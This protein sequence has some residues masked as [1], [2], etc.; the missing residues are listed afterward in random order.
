MLASPIFYVM[1][2]T[3]TCGAFSGLMCI[4]QVSTIAQKMIGMSVAAATTVVSILSLFNTAGRVVAGYISDKIG[5][6]NMLTIVFVL[7][8]MGLISLYTCNEGDV[9]KF[10]IGI[11]VVGLCFG[12]IMGIFPGFTADRF[13]SKNNS[14]NY[15]IMFIG[16]ALAGVFGPTIMSNIYLKYNNYQKAFLIAIGFSVAGLGLTYLDRVVIK[17]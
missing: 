17:D 8:I 15:G 1:I 12:S 14:V 4:S 11:S 5:R 16:F 9:V 3:L 10:Y 6:I 13:G 7:L 2:F